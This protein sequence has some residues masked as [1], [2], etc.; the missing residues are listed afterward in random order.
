MS[1]VVLTVGVNARFDSVSGTT[2]CERIA[3]KADGASAP[4]SSR[5]EIRRNKRQSDK[6]LMSLLKAEARAAGVGAGGAAVQ[7]RSTARLVFSDPLSRGE[8]PLKDPEALT[9]RF[10]HPWERA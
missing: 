1:D 6:A 10:K 5:Q 3:F 7:N 2:T 8:K 9:E 4:V